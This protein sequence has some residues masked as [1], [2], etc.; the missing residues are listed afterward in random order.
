MFNKLKKVASL[1]ALAAAMFT[2]EMLTANTA[3]AQPGS[4]V[5]VSHQGGGDYI[6]EIRSNWDCGKM[7]WIRTSST[8]GTFRRSKYTCEQVGRHHSTHSFGRSDDDICDGMSRAS[9][10]S[11]IYH[12]DLAI[13][14]YD[15]G[16]I[17]QICPDIANWSQMMS[18]SNQMSNFKQ[19]KR[20]MYT[21]K[22]GNRWNPPNRG[23]STTY[24]FNW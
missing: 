22:N 15:W 21:R 8:A 9:V 4:R 1:A 11:S 14:G 10:T 16:Y 24:C 12:Q 7:W 20:N 18:C 5:C 6:A 23:C 2:G 3:S 19:I 17:N 13:N